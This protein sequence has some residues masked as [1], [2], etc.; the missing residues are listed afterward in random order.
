MVGLLFILE[1]ILIGHGSSILLFKFGYMF[2]FVLLCLNCESY[3]TITFN[4][5]W[6][7]LLF[8]KQWSK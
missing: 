5:F 6:G 2:F 8:D 1:H 3:F 4:Y 7:V